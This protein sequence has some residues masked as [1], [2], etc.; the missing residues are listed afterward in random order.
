MQETWCREGNVVT[1]FM[2]MP[3][4]GKDK[5]AGFWSNT[6]WVTFHWAEN[7]RLFKPKWKIVSSIPRLTRCTMVPT[8]YIMI[9]TVWQYYTEL[10][11]KTWNTSDNLSAKRVFLS[12]SNVSNTLV[13]RI[14]SSCTFQFLTY[15]SKTLMRISRVSAKKMWKYQKRYCVNYTQT[16]FS[17]FLTCSLVLVYIE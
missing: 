1:H 14:N 3:G 13:G 11:Y 8:L 17:L 10:Y 7:T 5:I 9:V 16:C 2:W 6:S 4:V 15:F 12:L